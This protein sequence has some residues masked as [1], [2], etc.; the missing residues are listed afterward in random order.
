MTSNLSL[1]ELQALP[2]PQLR[3]MAAKLG[4]PLRRD[5]TAAVIAK[6]IYDST[7]GPNERIV[8][9][10]EDSNRPK[11]GWA[12]IQILKDPSPSASNSD[13]FLGNNGYC[14]LVKRGVTV[15]VPIKILRGSLMD[16]K[17]EVLRVDETKTDPEEMY[18]WEIVHS[19]PFIV[20]DVN[21]GPDP[22]ATYENAY[23]KKNKAKRVFKEIN[24]YWP[25]PQVLREWLLSKENQELVAKH[26]GD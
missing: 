14:V 18:K 7:H 24:G 9:V 15:D 22:R 17:V 3:S 4:L 1:V 16:S 12:R 19:Y 2:I 25:K 26:K 8:A 21:E 5:M 20:Y 23:K 10:A 13:V 6:M 11:P